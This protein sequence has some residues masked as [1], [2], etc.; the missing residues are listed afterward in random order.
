[1]PADLESARLFQVEHDTALASIEPCEIRRESVES[2]VV[3]AREIA[4]IGTLYLDYVGTQIG[5]LTRAEWRGD[6]LFE[7]DHAEIARAAEENPWA[8]EGP[9]HLEQ[10]LADVGEDQVGRDGRHLIKTRLA[11]LALDVVLSSETE[12]AMRLQ[13]HIGCLP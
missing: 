9:R 3:S 2:T 7:S 11:K 1:M 12:P 13:A 8:L 6:S 5:E 4:A 10:M